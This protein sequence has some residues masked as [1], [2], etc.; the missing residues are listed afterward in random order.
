MC[1]PEEMLSKVASRLLLPTLE[2]DLSRSLARQLQQAHDMTDC[3]IAPV[4]HAFEPVTAGGYGATSP[5]QQRIVKVEYPVPNR[6]LF[7]D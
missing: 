2:R 6:G 7:Q 4:V 3:M 1:L 5:R